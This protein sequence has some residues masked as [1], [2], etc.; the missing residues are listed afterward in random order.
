ML[1]FVLLA[2][3]EEGARPFPEPVVDVLRRV[4]PC[5]TVAYRAWNRDQITVD[6]SFA[7]DEL[8]DRWPVWTR[9]PRFRR[10]DPHP[11][12]APS[13]SDDRPPM[14]AAECMARPLVLSDAISGRVFSQT[15]LYLELMRPFGVRDV[16]KIFLPR[17]DGI[18]A[19]FVFDTS[20]NGFSET[21]RT[22]VRRL[23]PALIQL[24][25]NAQLRS[26]AFAA[27]DRLKLLT[28]RELTILAR[29]ARGETNAEIAGALFIN[30]ST[31]RKHLEHI[32]KKLAVRNRAAAAGVY[33]QG[34]SLSENN[35]PFG[36]ARH[37][38]ATPF[39]GSTSPGGSTRGLRGRHLGSSG[40]TRGPE[41]CRATRA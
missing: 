39:A 15:G 24:Q 1:E 6:R 41:D 4:V 37:K 33:T 10:D 23:A 31:A 22:L 36:A 13:P 34:R 40:S 16:M 18:G 7:P 19:V 20:G 28:P 26:Q 25:R 9:Y 5:D 17:H 3:A 11:S 21:D 8:A 38:A 14:S 29:A 30:P 32:Y 35:E 27:D 12:E 2:A